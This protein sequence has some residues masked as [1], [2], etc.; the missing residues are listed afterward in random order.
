[1][2]IS[3]SL[4]HA[5]SVGNL[6]ALPLALVGGMVAGINPCC[7]A[8][9]PAAAGA[10]CA[11]PPGERR[12][13]GRN[14]MALGMGVALSVAVLGLVAVI[15][16]RVASIARPL[17]YL[18]AAIP[19]VMGLSRLGWI[20]LPVVKLNARRTAFGGAFGSGVLLSFVIGPCHTPVL[21]SVLSF[22][23]SQ[24]SFVHGALLLLSYGIGNSVPVILVGTASGEFVKRVE[25]SSLARWLNPMVGV[26]LLLLGFYLLWRI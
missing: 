12:Q 15:I 22:A 13:A 10:C 4:G 3:S 26:F 1:M 8:L 21:A 24:Q 17:Q 25:S 5:L 9:Y 23:A 6:A 16:G 14:A 2:D 18:I 19:I 20:R 11:V 7:L